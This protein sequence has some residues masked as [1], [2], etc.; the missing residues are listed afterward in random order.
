[1][2]SSQLEKIVSREGLEPVSNREKSQFRAL[3]DWATNSH[4]GG[5]ANIVYTL[6]IKQI[7]EISFQYFTYFHEHK[8]TGGYGHVSMRNVY[9]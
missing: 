7:G 9:L 4:G 8:L 2:R 6:C 5:I 3:T 1:M